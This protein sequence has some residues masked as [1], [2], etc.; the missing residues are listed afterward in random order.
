M[1]RW[2]CFL[3][4]L[5]SCSSH[6]K[7][8]SPI[9]NLSDEW[10]AEPGEGELQLCWWQSF[11]DEQL[12]TLIC[13]AH[14]SNHDLRLAKSRLCEWEAMRKQARSALL[15]QVN[16]GSLTTR[17]KFSENA[18]L[19]LGDLLRL[20]FGSVYESIYYLGAL[21]AWELDFFGERRA[22]LSASK[23]K[24][25]QAAEQI[26][27]LRRSIGGKV[28]MTYLQLRDQQHQLALLRERA[29]LVEEKYTLIK[30]RVEAGL[31]ADRELFKADSELATIREGI[32]L[33]EAGVRST[34]YQLAILIGGLPESVI[35][36]ADNP[37]EIDALLPHFGVGLRSEIV[38]RRPD[39]RA[40]E[41]ELI[42]AHH[43]TRA[44]C[45]ALF[46][47]FVLLGSGSFLSTQSNTLFDP[48]S[49]QWM[50]GGIATAPLFRGGYLSAKL[51]EAGC[52]E[53][54]AR[55]QYE[56]AVFTALNEAEDALFQFRQN[57]EAATSAQNSKIAAEKVVR[58]LEALYL[59]G[60]TRKINFVEAKLNANSR[61]AAE[62]TARTRKYIAYVRLQNA[63]GL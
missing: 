57:E 45:A 59:S 34:Q 50:E 4:L 20:G 11:K 6:Y 25:A 63:L 14:A 15:P 32:P 42:A 21:A 26:E 49:S 53:D 5:A 35:C 55:I 62:G 17:N 9:C 24:E 41:Q 13:R 38:R 36:L 58:D 18:P 2:I 54:Q 22:T 1:K 19:G 47:K 39:L 61:I 51:S 48:E 10:H 27:A 60:L 12:N 44:K 43:I 37:S 56:K 30:N 8:Y 33:L 40:A 52:K 46:P 7:P 29:A 31:E 28:A 3:C 16:I 23:A